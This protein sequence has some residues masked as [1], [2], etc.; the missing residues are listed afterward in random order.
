MS[1][2]LLPSIAAF[3]A[4]RELPVEAREWR[5]VLDLSELEPGDLMLFRTVSDKLD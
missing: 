4:D 5:R 1:D 3:R 2:G